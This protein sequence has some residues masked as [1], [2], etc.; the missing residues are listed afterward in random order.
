MEWK[1]S[2]IQA[3]LSHN[4][5]RTLFHPLIKFEFVRRRFNGVSA[6]DLG[7]GLYRIE[8]SGY[9]INALT[10]WADCIRKEYAAWSYWYLPAGGLEGKTVLDIGGGCG[11]TAL[12][13]FA[14]G[15]AKVIAIEQDPRAAQLAVLNGSAN[16]W[17]YQVINE[18][19]KLEHLAIPHDFMKSDIEGGERLFLDPSVKELGPCRIEIHGA[20]GPRF[21]AEQKALIAK[22]HLKP[23]QTGIWGTV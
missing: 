23:I 17:N 3:Y 11:E 12:F 19:A 1:K 10:Y 16:R 5:V 13:F 14:H 18:E 8:A 22:F 4:T 9:R 2:F 6:E 20:Y 7:K 15:A 21:M